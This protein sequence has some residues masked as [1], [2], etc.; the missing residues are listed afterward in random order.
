[1][2]YYIVVN[3]WNYPTESGRDI[4][5]DFDTIEEAEQVASQQVEEERDNFLLVNKGEI[6]EAACGRMIEDF[7]G[8]TT[9]YCLHSSPHEEE[10]M[11]FQSIIIKREI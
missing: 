10:D 9:C 11:W 6:Y 8:P 7:L 2:T 4:I 5:G 3:E 1:M